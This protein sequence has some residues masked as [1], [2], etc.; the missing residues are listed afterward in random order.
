M[1]KRYAI[2]GILVLISALGYIVEYNRDVGSLIIYE[3]QVDFNDTENLITQF[4]FFKH[5]TYN[6]TNTLDWKIENDTAGTPLF[7][8]SPFDTAL[9]HKSNGMEPQQMIY[10]GTFG[11]NG[12]GKLETFLVCYRGVTSGDMLNF[13][14]EVSGKSDNSPVIIGVESFDSKDNYLDSS[15]V[16]ISDLSEKPKRYNITYICPNNTHYIAVYIQCQEISSRSDISLIM[17][18]PRLTREGIGVTTE[19]KK[20]NKEDKGFLYLILATPLFIPST[21]ILSEFIVRIKGYRNKYTFSGNKNDNYQILV[22]IWGHIKYLENIE[23]LSRY[24]SHVTLCT[25][26]DESKEFYDSLNSIVAKYGFNVFVDKATR[27]DSIKEQE[28]SNKERSTSGR[29]RDSIIRNALKTVAT[30]YVVALDADS[31]TDKDMSLLVGEL[32]Y[33]CL[34]IASI[35]IVPDN[36]GSSFLTKLQVFE[37]DTAMNFRYLCPWLISGACHVAKT[38]VLENIMNRHSLFFQGNDVETGLL[39]KTIGYNVGHIPFIVR[40]SVP[41]NFESWI[42]QRLAW[43]GGE[44]RLYIMNLKFIFQ[45]PLFWFYGAVVTIG[46]FPLRWM[47]LSVLTPSL[48]II[49]TLYIGLILYTHWK[50]KNRWLLILPIYTLFI[51]LVM[52][53]LGVVWYFYMARKD[54]NYGIITTK[55]QNERIWDCK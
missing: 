52:T 10:K 44:F 35:R 55:I 5:D 43:A 20:N 37:Y 46:L 54:K 9:V 30:C 48:Y 17:G 4:Q 16:Y 34:D 49:L 19:V 21:I 7:A 27:L 38:Y 8:F 2:L 18:K 51:S 40:T 1:K 11:D 22:P 15:D 12:S 13:S 3:P 14:M 42:R 50:N 23:Y 25:T 39:A 32:E 24:G 26:G 31:I 33:R 36:G 28:T 47:S 41:A 53:P 45:Y 6:F 29:E